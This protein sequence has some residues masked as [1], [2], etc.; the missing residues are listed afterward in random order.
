MRSIRLGLAQINCTVGDLDGNAAKIKEY[1][2][3]AALQG[4]DLLAFPELSVSGYPPEDLL[5]KPQFIADCREALAQIV[6]FSR[7]LEE[8]TLILGC[9]DLKADVYNSA[10]IINNGR[11]VDIYHKMYLPNYGVFDEERY[12]KPGAEG[13]VVTVGGVLVGI[14]ICEDI[15]Y[16]DGPAR[17]E[18]TA[19]GAELIVNLNAS[20]YHVA[21][22]GARAHML[23]DRAADNLAAVAYVNMVGGQDE[24][25]F[26]GQS[27][28]YNQAGKRVAMGAQFEEELV[29][30]DIDAEAIAKARQ[31]HAEWRLIQ[32]EARK[33]ALPLRRALV[34]GETVDTAKPP[35][36]RV[37]RSEMEPVE[38]VFAAVK[39]GLGDYVRKNRFARVLVGLSGGV[40][41]A[42]AAALAVDA[43]GAANVTTVFMPSR[44]TSHES[45]QDAVATAKNLGTEFI[46]ISI[47]PIFT[48]YL[49]SLAP[50]FAGRPADAAEENLQARIRGNILMALSNKFGWLLLSTGNK[51]EMSVGY[52]TLYGDMSGGFAVLKDVPKTLVYQLAEYYNRKSGSEMIPARVLTKAPSAELRAGQ[53]DSDALPEYDVLDPIVRAY[54]EEDRANSEIVAA[55]FEA[56]TVAK[57]TEMVDRSEYKRRQAPPG[58]KI[59]SRAFGKDWRVPITNW[60]K[61]SRKNS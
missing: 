40:D 38:E 59:T 48:V 2:R 8:M 60:Y 16:P 12:F 49:E 6:E 1:C 24:L 54:V 39:L 45:V 9:V 37:E 4:V 21:K 44:F 61:E 47:E 51:S 23:A 22:G 56:A 41:S 33:R 46:D 7:E 13:L 25:V 15:W 19:G 42:L 34:G 53:K 3:R 18:A 27:L 30:I 20:P 17:T 36:K 55:G 32:A 5:L 11:V 50:I 52:A 35:I 28:V 31:E 57:V 43:I 14:S 10:A 26:D 29:V 58:V